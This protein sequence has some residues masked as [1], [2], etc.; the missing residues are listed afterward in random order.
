[1]GYSPRGHKESDMTEQLTL[2]LHFLGSDSDSHLSWPSTPLLGKFSCLPGVVPT[3]ACLRV[4]PRPT[5]LPPHREPQPSQTRWIPMSSSSLF[6]TVPH[7]MQPA[8]L[9]RAAPA[10]AMGVTVF[11]LLL[12]PVNHQVPYPS[13]PLLLFLTCLVHGSHLAVVVQSLSRVQLFATLWTAAHQ[14]FLS[15][16]ISQSVRR[17]MSIELVMPLVA[18]QS[19]YLYIQNSRELL[20]ASIYL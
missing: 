8:H 10:Q 18:P 3:P 14:A 1:M 9:G 13:Y 12:P 19:K 17:L 15:S 2:S 20:C 6:A 11:S 16:T 4:Q 5:Q 7:P